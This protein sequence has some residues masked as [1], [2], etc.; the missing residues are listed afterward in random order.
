MG[1]C[2]PEEDFYNGYNGNGLL[3]GVAVVQVI[4]FQASRMT[5][6]SENNA[7]KLIDGSQYISGSLSLLQNME[8]QR[9]WLNAGMI[10]VNQGNSENQPMVKAE[11]RTGHAICQSLE[12]DIGTGQGAIC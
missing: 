7:T 2:D 5:K 3:P 9:L 6:N 1:V 10:F 11:I 8:N 4:I 12:K